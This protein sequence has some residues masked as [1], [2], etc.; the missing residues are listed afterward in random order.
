ME[1]KII[2]NPLTHEV[3]YYDSLYLFNTSLTESD[4]FI[5]L[6]DLRRL[7]N[8]QIPSLFRVAIHRLDS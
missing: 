7:T 5:L 8:L 6:S 1:Y 3:S 2:F 4:V